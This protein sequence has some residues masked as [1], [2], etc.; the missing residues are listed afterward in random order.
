MSDATPLLSARI[1][2][3][4]GHRPG[5]A[6]IFQSF[7]LDFCCGG[8]RTLAEAIDVAHVQPED[9]LAALAVSTAATGEAGETWA[10]T[11]TSALIE[12][13]R[14]RYH[15]VHLGELPRLR[16]LA[17]KVE[18][19]HRG[20]ADVPSGLADLL[21]RVLADVR[22][23][24]QREEILLFPLLV[25]GGGPM[26]ESAIQVMRAEHDD[27]GAALAL[28]DR[29]THDRTAP[30]E[31]CATWRALCLGLTKFHDDLTMHVHLENNILFPRFER[32][33]GAGDL[34]GNP[35]RA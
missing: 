18:A 8:D 31:A 34:S 9:V 33:A 22:V 15:A 32:A 17:R 3:L 13:I 20:H 35:G 6:A 7:G 25:Q 21:A 11:P 26:A 16:D 23:H 19:A 24:Q 12:H 28:I 4:A 27:H 30:A 29:I 10:E 2:D 14:T 5:A 1:G